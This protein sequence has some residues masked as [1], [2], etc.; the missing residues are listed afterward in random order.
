[1]G[2][3]IAMN[4]LSAGIPVTILETKQEAL[5]RGVATIRQNYEGSLKRGKLTPEK[6]Q[7]THRAAQADAVLRRHRDTPIW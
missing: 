1:M 6:L 4:F 3:G 2:G 7:Q 5:D